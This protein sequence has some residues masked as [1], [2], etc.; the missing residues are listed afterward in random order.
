[1]KKFKIFCRYF[2][3]KKYH[4]LKYNIKLLKTEIFNTPFLS[5]NILASINIFF[6]VKISTWK[7]ELHRVNIFEISKVSETDIENNISE[8]VC[9]GKCVSSKWKNKVFFLIVAQTE[10][11]GTDDRRCMYFPCIEISRYVYRVCVYR[12]S[13]RDTKL[14][15]SRSIDIDSTLES[16]G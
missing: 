3:H 12:A 2:F 9:S 11:R 7:N 16:R 8:N 15:S 1:M 14:D 6:A 10:R 13:V 4:V 5:S